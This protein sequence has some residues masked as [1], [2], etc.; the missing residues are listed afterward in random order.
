MSHALFQRESYWPYLPLKIGGL[1]IPVFN[2]TSYLEYEN[3]KLLAKAL[4]NKI[5]QLARQEIRARGRNKKNQKSSHG[6]S[7][8]RKQ[9]GSSKFNMN[10]QQKPQIDINK[11]RGC[12]SWVTV[13][14]LSDEVY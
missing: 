9:I 6:N 5:K 14:S 10:Q 2:L 8:G 3:S 4:C 11:E 7:V 13:L 1:G 12:L